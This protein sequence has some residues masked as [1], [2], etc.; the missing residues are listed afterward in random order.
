VAD[1]EHPERNRELFVQP[2]WN[3]EQKGVLHN[4]IL[5]EAT[6]DP[7][8]FMAGKFKARLD[9]SSSNAILIEL[10]SM[11]HSKLNE[12]DKFDATKAAFQINCARTQ[13]AEN[14]AR[15]KIMGDP[16]RQKKHFLLRFPDDMILSNKHYSPNSQEEAGEIE[17]EIVYIET[18][19][20]VPESNPEK[21]YAM[22]ESVVQWKVS[23]AEAEPRVVKN[24]NKAG[25]NKHAEKLAQRL[26]GMNVDAA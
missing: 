25:S 14:V 4:G 26:Q 13:E 24:T 19:W 18:S 6:C 23:I 10:P 12:S 3:V 2:F 7:R 5:I 17:M 9:P 8:D 15:N 1:L 11:R 20:T 21:K 22:F 16:D